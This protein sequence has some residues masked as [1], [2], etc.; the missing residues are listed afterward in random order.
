MRFPQTFFP[1]SITVTC[2]AVLLGRL[3][4]L[5]TLRLVE[6]DEFAT[7]FPIYL[8]L[9]LIGYVL[10]AS[11]EYLRNVTNE[12]RPHF[13]DLQR[14]SSRKQGSGGSQVRL[15]LADQP[16]LPAECILHPGRKVC[17]VNL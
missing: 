10:L 4:Y 7:S 9:G 16:V 2:T 12:N 1:L 8:R 14:M 11:L 13:Q 5:L 15:L 17:K 3:L 6:F